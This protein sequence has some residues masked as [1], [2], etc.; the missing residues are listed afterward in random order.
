[1]EIIEKIV[2]FLGRLILLFVLIWIIVNEIFNR[3]FS[4]LTSYGFGK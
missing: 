2:D 1:M 4:K 3:I